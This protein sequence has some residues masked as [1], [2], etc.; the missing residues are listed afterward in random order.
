MTSTS[1]AGHRPRPSTK[2]RQQTEQ[3]KLASVDV[4]QRRDVLVDDRSEHHSLDEPQR[5]R[6]TEHERR[7]REERIPE[8]GLEARQDD[9]KL[10]DKARRARQARISQREEHHERGEF[11]HRIDDAAV[12]GNL[13]A[14]HAVVHDAD[15]QEQRAGYQAMGNHLHHAAGDAE[16]DALRTATV[17][18]YCPGNEKAER[19]EA[20][21]G[22]R[23]IG[24][25]FL[26]VLLNQRD[27]A[28]VDDGDQ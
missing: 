26:H 24:D 25:Q 15:T 5:I 27:E 14:V 7:R 9:E 6:R 13:P 10:A 18:E 22:D 20:H 12:I 28:D 1:G 19:H 4:G 23:R 8:I 11:R 17:R 2:N 3:Q 21:V 16:R